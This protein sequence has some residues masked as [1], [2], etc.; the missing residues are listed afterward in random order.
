METVR[1]YAEWSYSLGLA[2]VRLASLAGFRR[3]RG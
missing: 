2:T 1:T 3:C